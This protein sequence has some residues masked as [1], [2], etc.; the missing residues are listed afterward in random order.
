MKHALIIVV[1]LLT[2]AGCS[3]LGNFVDAGAKANDAAAVS[4][5]TTI[6]RGISIG[7]WV[8]HYGNDADKAKAWKVLC[9]DQIKAM[10]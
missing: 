7:A 3:T 10:P 2:L 9:N 8:R 5:E 4:A 1:A 6:C